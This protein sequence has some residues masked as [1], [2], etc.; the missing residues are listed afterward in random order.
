MPQLAF[1]A[2]S[3]ALIG[4]A[5]SM[6]N[7]ATGEGIFYG[8]EAGLQ[9]GR[10]LIGA[11]NGFGDIQ[12]ALVAYERQ[13]RRTFS[14]HF[15]GNLILRKTIQRPQLMERMVTACAK[16]SDLC[17]DYIEYMMGNESGVGSKPLYR[18]ALGTLFA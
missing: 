7:P 11:K 5:A 15:R 16:D 3:A 6:I 14:A 8:M 9:L 4:D 2:K 10:R 18:L 12:G 17:C 13:F 1:P